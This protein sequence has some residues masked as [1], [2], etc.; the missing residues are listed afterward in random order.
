MI[1][2]NLLPWREQQRKREKQQLQIMILAGL[3]FACIVVFL[4]D[5][6]ANHILQRQIH[7]NQQLQAELTRC[8]E[9]IKTIAG[10]RQERQSLINK[11]KIIQGLQL[12][13]VLSIHLLDELIQI[14]PEGVY[15]NQLD[16]FEDKVTLLGYAQSNTQISRLMRNIS[17]NHWLHDPILTEIKK[18]EDVG[19]LDSEQHEENEFKLSFIL[20]GN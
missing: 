17:T 20:R 9:Q 12:S 16:R 8:D 3:V 13:R 18:T 14:L 7:R 19:G 6:Y 2:I 4:L 11:M 1:S 5:C 10:L 15:L